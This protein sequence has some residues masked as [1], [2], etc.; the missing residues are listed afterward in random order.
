MLF[1]KAFPDLR[2]TV[3][4]LIAEGD[5]VAV[6][7]SFHGTHQG[8]FLGISSTGRQVVG[9]GIEIV[10]FAGGQIVEEWHKY[11]LGLVRQL[12][13]PAAPDG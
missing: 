2:F 8:E 10:R 1:R 7:V 13:A 4:D 9:T 12:Q 11:V 3:E 5:R 6:R